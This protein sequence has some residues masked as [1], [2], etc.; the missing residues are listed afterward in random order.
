MNYTKELADLFIRFGNE[1][2]KLAMQ[3]EE[4][5]S[6]EENKEELLT[7]KMVLEKFPIFN[8]NSLYRATTYSGLISY[9]LGKHRYYKAVDIEEWINLQ[10]AETPKPYVGF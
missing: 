4:T 1:L 9:K 2:N 8:E 6:E 7:K 3:A 5:K 10:K